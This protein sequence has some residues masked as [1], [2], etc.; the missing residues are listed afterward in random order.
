MLTGYIDDVAI[1]A[2]GKTTEQTCDALGKI[3]EKAQ[4]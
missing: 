2:S 3:L 4:R 1:L